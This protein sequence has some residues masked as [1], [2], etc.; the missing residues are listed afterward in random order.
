[1]PKFLAKLLEKVV[2]ERSWDV[3]VTPSKWASLPI[4]RIPEPF[5]CSVMQIGPLFI[6][7]WNDPVKARKKAFALSK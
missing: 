7:K 3:A 4:I 5:G 2:R 6:R 1:M